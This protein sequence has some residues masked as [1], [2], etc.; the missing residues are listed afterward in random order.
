MDSGHTFP[1]V[2]TIAVLCLLH[3]ALRESKLMLV[4]TLL[5]LRFLRIAGSHEVRN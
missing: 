1:L 5:L 2:G 3:R 4:D